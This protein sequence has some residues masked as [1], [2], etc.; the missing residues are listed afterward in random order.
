MIGEQFEVREATANDI[1]GMH[2]VRLS[3]TENPFSE[4]MGIT[5]TS[6]LPFV[7]DHG[8]WVAEVDSRIVGFAI[9]DRPA[10]SVWALFVEPASE[11]V[12]IGRALHQHMIDYVAR[13]G[14][15]HI[16]LTTARDSRAAHF[17]SQLGWTDIGLTESGELK[18]ERAVEPIQTRR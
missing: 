4:R 1:P 14:I 15:G 12:G 10:A 3:V 11:G 18:F 16:S 7:V 5:E 13:Q 6:Y 2:R 9:L 8:A 17:Y